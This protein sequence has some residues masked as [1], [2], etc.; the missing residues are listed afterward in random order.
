MKA[1]PDYIEAEDQTS[2]PAILDATEPAPETQNPG[3]VPLGSVKRHKSI[4]DYM[5]P[6][7]LDGS[8]YLNY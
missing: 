6:R 2:Q 1:R 8:K 7:P 4:L 5:A 3:R